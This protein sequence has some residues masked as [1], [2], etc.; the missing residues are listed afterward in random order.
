MAIDMDLKSRYEE[1]RDRISRAA[2]RAGRDSSEVTMI[3]VTKTLPHERVR[4]A[5]D[6]GIREVGENRV[7]ELINKKTV[8]PDL[9]LRWHLIGHL[10]RNKV[11]QV[12][13]EVV[14]IHSV[15]SVHL[16]T[17]IAEVAAGAASPVDVLVQVNTSSETTKFGVEPA[18]ART[19]A[20]A[21]LAR[22]ALRLRGLMTLG[23]L[24]DDGTA[25]RA[26]FRLLRRTRE[27]LGDLLPAPAILSM[28]MSGDFEIAVEEGAT[29]VRIGTALFGPRD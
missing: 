28:G 7:Q 17:R 3:A 8:L 5:F 11:K 10:Q 12:L 2:V 25:I 24:T 27:D 4:A 1:I 20:E 9:P 16:I 22:P 21:I 29:H 23:P 15:D 14:L 6:L 26:S 13:G 18:G 19:L